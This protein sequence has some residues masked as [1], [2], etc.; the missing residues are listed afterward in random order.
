MR[1]VNKRCAAGALVP[2]KNHNYTLITIIAVFFQ[3]IDID[4][5][6]ADEEIA[7]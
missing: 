5:R 2:L 3:H 7:Y 4:S 1:S 6:L